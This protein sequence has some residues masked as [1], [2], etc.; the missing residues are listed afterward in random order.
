ML[1]DFHPTICNKLF[2]NEKYEW[3]VAGAIYHDVKPT[4]RLQKAGFVDTP[5]P[6]GGTRAPHDGPA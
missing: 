3:C 2:H 6:A 1:Y 4:S 5:V